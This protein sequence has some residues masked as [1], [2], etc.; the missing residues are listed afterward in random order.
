MVGFGHSYRGLN[1]FRD[2]ATGVGVLPFASSRSGCDDRG[3]TRLG[4]REAAELAVAQAVVD[5]GEEFACHCGAGDVH[6]APVR[7][8]VVV[9]FEFGPP[10]IL[11][12]ASMAAHRTSFDPCFG[13]L[14]PADLAV[15]L[16]V[17]G[18]EPRPRAHALGVGNRVTSP[19][20]TTNM[21]PSVGPTPSSCWIV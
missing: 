12:M 8:A 19:I 16:L 3:S 14:A 6:A 13:D 1:H 5:E 15:R 18:S 20:S 21:A 9:G 4:S 11:E 2:R 10:R 7:D 17:L